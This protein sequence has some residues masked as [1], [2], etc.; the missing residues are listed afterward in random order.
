MGKNLMWHKGNPFLE[1]KRKLILLQKQR[2]RLLKGVSSV[3]IY[4]A[5]RKVIP[6]YLLFYFFRLLVSVG[7]KEK[8]LLSGRYEM[9]AKDI[10]R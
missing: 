10:L 4:L 8:I 2:Q 1:A 9:Q 6:P 3:K 5:R 7:N